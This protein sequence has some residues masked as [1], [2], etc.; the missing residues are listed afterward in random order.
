MNSNDFPNYS[1]LFGDINFREADEARSVYSP[2]AYL[3]DLLQLIDDQFVDISLDLDHRRQDIKKIYLDSENT[4]TLLPYLDIVNEVLEK[5]VEN[6]VEHGQEDAYEI[7]R[8]ADYPLNLPFNRDRD[9]IALYEKY[10]GVTPEEFHKA[11]AQPYNPDVVA[12]E[13]LG[14]SEEDVA[15]ITKPA[16]ETLE[17]R[18]GDRL[19][20]LGTPPSIPVSEFLAMTGLTHRELKELLVGNLDARELEEQRQSIFFCNASSAVF[21][22][23][24]AAEA[25]IVWASKTENSEENLSSDLAKQWLDRTQRLIR[26]SRI[27]NL[28]IVDLDLIIR[29]CCNNTLNS[30]SLQRIAII[31]HLSTTF[32]LMLDETCALF[33]AMSDVGHGT[34]ELAADLFH[35]VF[36]GSFANLAKTYVGKSSHLPIQLDEYEALTYSGDILKLDNKPYRNRIAQ[37]LKISEKQL[38]VAIRGF[39]SRANED[40]EDED[41]F[42]SLWT[43][44]DEEISMLSTLYR[45][46]KLATVLDTSLEDLFILLDILERDQAARQFTNSDVFIDYTIAERNGYI[47]LRQG[48]TQELLWLV[49]ILHSLTRWLMKYSLTAEELLKISTGRYRR[50]LKDVTDLSQQQELDIEI[51]TRKEKIVL[52]NTLYSQL[53]PWL[54]NQSSFANNIFDQRFARIIYEAI[55]STALVAEA[56]FRL[57]RFHEQALMAAAHETIGRVDQL[58]QTDFRGLGLEAKIA[59]KIFANLVLMGYL[60][61]TGRLNETMMPESPSNFNLETDFTY[62]QETLFEAIQ[63]LHEEYVDVAIYPSDLDAKLASL[64][65][66]KAHLDELYDN[67]IFNGFLSE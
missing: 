30:A 51:I 50:Y 3:A 38:Q 20:D 26:L 48:S 44:P 40:I 64:D 67:L 37:S 7:L 41:M 8:L 12:Q 10:L 9:R 14:L 52:L 46:S 21:A 31:K 18:Y 36:N 17:T 42:D 58:T 6:S 65:L 49:Q 62:L 23:Y 27:T 2:A 1:K 34:E 56:D 45:V 66:S 61:T 57:V 59:D 53:K 19:P 25:N 35:R 5:K 54:L 55:A 22:K 33:S 29:N 47:I 16:E 11:F 32:D 60:T 39:R 28:T 24:D 13:Y 15:I 43:S 63:A 4:F